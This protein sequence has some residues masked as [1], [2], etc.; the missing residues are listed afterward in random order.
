[1][2]ATVRTR[3]L[4]QALDQTPCLLPGTH[5][6]PSRGGTCNPRLPWVPLHPAT[7]LLLPCREC[8]HHRP[9]RHS[10]TCRLPPSPCLHLLTDS[11]KCL[12]LLW[13]H[14]LLECRLSRLLQCL[15]RP[16]RWGDNACS[17]ECPP[18]PLF[19]TEAIRACPKWPLL[20]GEGR[21]GCLRL[22]WATCHL[23]CHPGCHLECR[24]RQWEAC[25][26][27][28]LLLPVATF[29]LG[30]NR[31]N[32]RLLKINHHNNITTTLRL[33]AKFA[34]LSPVTCCF[35]MEVLFSCS[36]YA[37]FQLTLFE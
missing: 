22:L 32:N 29:L 18:L 3:C 8:P 1:M 9:P 12:S 24:R 2:S 35:F 17:M 7:H 37:S 26:Q 31:T 4:P 14:L 15:R 27:V 30:S 10:P 33:L 28:C 21:Q 20:Q 16:R 34:M 19:R 11:L 6:T 36:A 25:L 23:E 5:T 13:V